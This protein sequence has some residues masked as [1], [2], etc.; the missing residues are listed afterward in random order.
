MEFDWICPV[1]GVATNR[2]EFSFDGVSNWV[3]WI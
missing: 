1:G 2:E 3:N